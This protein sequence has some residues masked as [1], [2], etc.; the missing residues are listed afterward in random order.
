M[1]AGRY[2]LLEPVAEG[3]MGSVWTVR[4]L[5]DGDVKAAKLL[6]Q[7]DAGSLL[8]FIREQSMRIDHAHVVTPYS[9]AGEDDRV[10]FTMPLVHGGSVATLLGDFGALPAA[11]VLTLLDQT[12]AGLEAVHAAGIVHRD[13]KPG[14]LL[15]R[16]TGAAE[17]YLLLTDFGV[18]APVDEPRMTR[19]SQVIGSPG[20]MSPE[21]LRGADPEPRQDLYAVGMVGLEMI[22]GVR[23]PGALGTA[24]KRAGREPSLQPLVDLLVSA[25]S[26]D[27]GERPSSATN[28]RA[29]LAAL[30]LPASEPG[31]GPFVFDHFAAP[32]PL[33]PARVLPP[34][35]PIPIPVPS[36]RTRISPAPGEV[37]TEPAARPGRTRLKAVL[38]LVTGALCAVAALVVLL[39]L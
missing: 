29:Q 35:I 16:A 32:V 14:N 38:L 11:W 25:I 28:F 6:R 22:S 30:E 31:D 4:D 39:S 8:R 36:R 33:R 18:A 9:W 1:F 24:T 5:R 13:V 17:P 34:P 3:G 37:A 7:S 10:L 26:P 2:E 27:L 19:A 12:L 20:Y 15:L 21:Q 23:P